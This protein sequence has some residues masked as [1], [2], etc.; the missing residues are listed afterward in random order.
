MQAL[1]SR[2]VR[3]NQHCIFVAMASMFWC[4]TA[5][6]LGVPVVPDVFSSNAGDRNDGLLALGMR[7]GVWYIGRKEMFER[8][9][10]GRDA[11]RIVRE[12]DLTTLNAADSCQDGKIRASRPAVVTNSEDS[13]KLSIGLIGTLIAWDATEIP[14]NAASGPLG[15]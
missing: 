9:P 4:V 11:R 7:G 10:S 8:E 13:A 6:S 15:S 14:I 3:L 12:F 5:T 2:G 1:R